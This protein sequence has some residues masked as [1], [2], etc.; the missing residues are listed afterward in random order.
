MLVVSKWSLR[1]EYTLKG[2]PEGFCGAFNFSCQLRSL[3]LLALGAMVR[4][5]QNV[6]TRDLPV[7]AR[8]AA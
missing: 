8:A 2:L 4:R 3:T 1:I 6:K 7:I 5:S